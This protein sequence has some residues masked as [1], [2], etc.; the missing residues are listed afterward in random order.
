MRDS[1]REPVGKR[2]LNPRMRY[3]RPHLLRTRDSL[4]AGTQILLRHLVL[5]LGCDTEYH[6]AAGLLLADATNSHVELV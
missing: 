2:L 1:D 5:R 3:S 4:R 6:Q